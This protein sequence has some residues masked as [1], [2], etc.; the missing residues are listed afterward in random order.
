MYNTICTIHS[1]YTVTLYKVENKLAFAVVRRYCR[2]WI[3]DRKRLLQWLCNLR[4]LM[5]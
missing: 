2:K 4:I 3:R 5:W 1:K